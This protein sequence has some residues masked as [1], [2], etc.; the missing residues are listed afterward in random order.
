[1]PSNRDVGPGTT[2]EP[3]WSR[4][5]LMP[6]PVTITPVA[7]MDVNYRYGRPSRMT[8]EQ[9]RAVLVLETCSGRDWATPA[10]GTP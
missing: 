2:D 10:F 4:L 8:T 1:M 7:V 5:R 6:D 3:R 9:Q